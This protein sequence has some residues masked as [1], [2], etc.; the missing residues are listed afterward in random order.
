MSRLWVYLHTVKD[1]SDIFFACFTSLS[2]PSSTFGK[3][4]IFS[5]GRFL[6]IDKIKFLARV[7][8][9]CILWTK[10]MSRIK[11]SYEYS[12]FI[13]CKLCYRRLIVRVFNSNAFYGRFI[14]NW[15]RLRRRSGITCKFSEENF[16]ILRFFSLLLCIFEREIDSFAVLTRL[17]EL[18]FPMNSCF[19]CKGFLDILFRVLPLSLDERFLGRTVRCLCWCVLKL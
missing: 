14:F 10:D 5:R 2:F 18:G 11:W 19:G 17:T 6:F 15:K 7:G 1:S 3:A 16:N 12:P 9:S 8:R 13:V 4:G